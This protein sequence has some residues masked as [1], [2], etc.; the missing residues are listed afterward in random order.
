MI[1]VLYFV[2]IAKKNVELNVEQERNLSKYVD[3][4]IQYF[5]VTHM[6]SAIHEWLSLYVA[7]IRKYTDTL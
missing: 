1:S 6:S 4:L 7:A 2:L 3:Q 5:Q